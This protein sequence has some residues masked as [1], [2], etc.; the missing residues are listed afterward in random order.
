MVCKKI[1]IKKSA[2]T[3]VGLI[4]ILL[5]VM[6]M[7]FLGFSYLK[8]QTDASGVSI[9]S[10][11][12]TTF[13]ELNKSQTIIDNNVNAIETNISKIT[14]A[15]SIYSVAVNGFKSL[16]NTLKLTFSFIGAS[17]DVTSGIAGS[18]MPESYIPPIVKVLVIIGITTF[19]VLLVLA[20]LKGDQKII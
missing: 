17:V 19:A 1:M 15:P 2:G 5:I 10:R 12:V 4:V 9:P 11:F 3:L 14:E 18:I 7:F 20:I 13:S 16:G 6:G 8:T